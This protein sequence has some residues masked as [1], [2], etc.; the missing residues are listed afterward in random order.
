MTKP[1]GGCL[2]EQELEKMRGRIERMEAA[3]TGLI[4]LVEYPLHENPRLR[5]KPFKEFKEGIK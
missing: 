4:Y 1:P 3:I 2:H 5:S